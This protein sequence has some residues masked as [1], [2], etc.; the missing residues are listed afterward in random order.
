MQTLSETSLTDFRNALTPATLQTLRVIS[1]GLAMG[2]LAF[3]AVV[4]V[5]SLQ[6]ERPGSTEDEQLMNILTAGVFGFAI[7][8]VL[9]GR[10]VADRQ[11]S[12]ANLQYAARA[13][14]GV[15]TDGLRVTSAGDQCLA[16]IRST[17]I[18]RLALAEAVGYSGLVVTLVGV[19]TGGVY[20]RPAYLVNLVYPLM[21]LV[22]IT[23]TF[24]TAERLEEIFTRRIQKTG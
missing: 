15:G 22:Y 4:L 23:S 19:M 13:I 2:L 3:G 7:V 6:Q 16:I 5:L 12:E 17:V 1:L 11:Y 20:S 21:A 10:V 8:I 9:T 14:N 18:I 24:P